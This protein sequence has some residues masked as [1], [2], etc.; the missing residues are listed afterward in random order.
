MANTGFNLNRGIIRNFNYTNLP[1]TN[2]QNAPSINRMVS[3]QNN[4][5][6]F[7]QTHGA[8]NIAKIQNMKTE[9]TYHNS[10]L[11]TVTVTGSV[12]LNTENLS[13]TQTLSTLG[14]ITS[15]TDNLD[16]SGLTNF[17]TL[18]SS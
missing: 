1:P 5:S 9:D 15:A 12:T 18:T 3:I 16:V 2:V 7:I 13:T 6:S 11:N 8:N 4:L 10:D 14:T 17:F